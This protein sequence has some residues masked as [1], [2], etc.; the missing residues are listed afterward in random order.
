[1][2]YAKPEPRYPF[3]VRLFFASAIEKVLTGRADIPSAL[4]ECEEGIN[5]YIADEKLAEKCPN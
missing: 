5:G 2:P 3:D 4:A 1:M